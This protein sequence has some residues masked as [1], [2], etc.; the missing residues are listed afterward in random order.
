MIHFLRSINSINPI[1]IPIKVQNLRTKIQDYTNKQNELFPKLPVTNF[2]LLFLIS[3]CALLTVVVFQAVKYSQELNASNTME[4]N[5]AGDTNNNYLGLQIQIFDRRRNID[6]IRNN[7]NPRNQRTG[8]LPYDENS[9]VAKWRASL[10]KSS[11]LYGRRD[12]GDSS[13]DEKY[14]SD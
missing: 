14:F 1:S 9:P 12:S 5:H 10:R 3:Y 8:Y 13:S 11:T 2:E 6:F 4:N 7:I